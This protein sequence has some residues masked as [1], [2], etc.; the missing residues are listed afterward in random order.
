M[1]TISDEVVALRPRL[2]ELR[3]GLHQHP[4]LGFQ[5]VRTSGLI[6]RRLAELGYAVRTGLGKTGVTGFLAG[7][8]SGGTVL[9][10]TEIDAL[11]IQEAVEA[12]W[13]STAPGAMHA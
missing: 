9:I 2:I 10:R 1:P 5:E 13:K 11:P 3:R 6:A 12:P 8:R 7:A 4:E